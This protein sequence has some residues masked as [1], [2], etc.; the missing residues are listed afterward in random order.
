MQ[1]QPKI[2][3]FL[4]QAAG[5]E[6]EHRDRT[7]RVFTLAVGRGFLGAAHVLLRGRPMLDDEMFWG[8]ADITERHSNRQRLILTPARHL[9]DCRTRRREARAVLNQGN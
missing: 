9:P 7:V 4:V 6:S 3:E 5:L 2:G 8:V 1:E